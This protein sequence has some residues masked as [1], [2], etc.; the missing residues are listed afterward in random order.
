MKEINPI[1]RVLI[2]LVVFVLIFALEGC[3]AN[4]SPQIVDKEHYDMLLEEKTEVC[5][6]DEDNERYIDYENLVDKLMDSAKSMDIYIPGYH[7]E[8]EY[9]YYIPPNIKQRLLEDYENLYC[10]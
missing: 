2:A 7:E 8:Y 1:R 10:K 6:L 5:I 4:Y 9:V 3:G